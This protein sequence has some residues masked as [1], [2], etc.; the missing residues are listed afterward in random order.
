MNKWI[1]IL[2]ISVLAVGS[3]ILEEYR[4]KRIVKE[5]LKKEEK[6]K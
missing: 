2:A 3:S 4:V 1:N 5:E 6:S